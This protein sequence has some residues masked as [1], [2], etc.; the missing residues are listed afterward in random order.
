MSKT[1]HVV[2]E[3]PVVDLEIVQEMAQELEDYIVKDELYRAMTVRTSAGD[4]R[5]QMTGGDLLTRLYRIRGA[6]EQLSPSQQATLDALQTQVDETI[7]SLRT[8]F[9]DRLQR[10]M[11]ARLDSLRWFLDDCEGDIQRCRVDFPYEM[12]NRQ[13]IEEVMKRVGREV[14][15]ELETQLQSIDTR[16]RN[17]TRVTDFIWDEQLRDTFPRTPYWYLYVRP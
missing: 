15:P 1:S 6:R 16:I 13:R 5:L 3:N 8:R 2:A 14:K 10:E 4:Q 7:Y 9:H 12:R 11:K 17:I